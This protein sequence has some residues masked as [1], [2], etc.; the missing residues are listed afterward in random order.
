MHQPNEPLELLLRETSHGTT[1]T[2]TQTN[3]QIAARVGSV[4]EVVS[5]ALS[6]LQQAG[7]ILI[8]DRKLTIPDLAVL[9]AF[10]EQ[11]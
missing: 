9:A 2:L 7:L 3:Q 4:R 1:I 5:R 11:T 10:A 6:R 8:D